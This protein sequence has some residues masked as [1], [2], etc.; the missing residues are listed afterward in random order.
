MDYSTIRQVKSLEQ[1][2]HKTLKQCDQAVY[3]STVFTLEQL[4]FY[5]MFHT[6]HVQNVF[7]YLYIL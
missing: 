6:A 1:Q 7:N 4:L 3:F 5:S 2:I